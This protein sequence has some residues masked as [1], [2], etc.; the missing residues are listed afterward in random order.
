MR[1]YGTEAREV[2][3]LGPAPLVAGAPVLA[4]EVDWA[5]R[6][7]GAV[8]LEDL[9]YRRLR[10]AWY[11]PAARDAAVEP[12]AARMASLLGWDAGRRQTEIA[13][14]RARL[15]SELAFLAE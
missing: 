6:E 14:V 9:V 15:A 11:V 3:R 12:A 2:T 13:Q 4:S 8:T 7:L 5:V 10:T 1:L